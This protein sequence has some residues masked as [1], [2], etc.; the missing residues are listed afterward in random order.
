MSGAATGETGMPRG[1]VVFVGLMTLAAIAVAGIVAPLPAPIEPTWAALPVLALLLLAATW[2][3]V[4]FRYGGSVD[5]VNLIEA[6]LAPMLIAFPP[7]VVVAVAAASQIANGALRRLPLVKTVFNTAMWAVAAGLGSLVVAAAE[8]G[9]LWPH[10]I[11]QLLA[12]LAVVGIVNTMAFATVLSLVQGEPL[13]RLLTR[14]V[15]VVQLG[16]I[17]GWIV[18]AAMGVL[19]A[20]S[21]LASPVAVALFGVPL[22]VLHLAYRSYSTARADQIRLAS[23]HRAARSLAEPLQPLSAVPEF[24][25]E[26]AAAFDAGAAELV[27]RVDAGREIH[28]YQRP[29]GTYAV[30]AEDQDVASLEGVLAASPGVATVG[31]QDDGAVAAALRAAGAQDCLAAPLLD[32]E[33]LMGAV[34]VLDRGGF[35]GSRAG[36]LAIF[37]ALARETAGAL[38]KGRL[39]GDVLEERRKLAEIVD[40]ASDGICTFAEDGTVLTWNP[41]LEQITG[42]PAE[43]VVG[44]RDL[45][46]RLHVRTADGKPLDLRLRPLNRLP[47]DIRL[48]N[49]SGDRRHLTCSYSAGSKDLGGA[50]LIVMAR[51]VTPAEEHEA[52]RAQFSEL[53]E[54]DAARRVV[55][56]RLQETVVPPPIAVPGAEV[57][58]A[59]EASDPRAPTG[60]DLYDWQILPNGEL[61]VAVVDVLGHGVAATKDALAV[62]HTLRVLTASGTGLDDIIARADQ[63]LQAQHPD[64]VA[65][66]IVARYSPDTGR[67]R[68]AAGG[69]PPALVVTPRREVVQVPATGGVIGWPG[70]GSDNVSETVLEPG[71]ALVLYTDGLVEA[72]K[73]ILD[74]MEDLVRHAAEVAELPAAPF[75]R[76]LVVRALAGAER[77]DDTL[78]LVLRRDP[79]NALERHASWEMA[80]DA[81]EISQTRRALRDWLAQRGIDSMDACLA[82]G[83]LLANAMRSARTRVTLRASLADGCITLDIS[84]DGAGEPDLDGRGHVLPHPDTEQGRGLF[85]VR[86][87]SERVDVLST[88]E[89]STVRAV[90]RQRPAEALLRRSRRDVQDGA[91]LD[92][93]ALSS[94]EWTWA[95]RT[96]Y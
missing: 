87:L 26:L 7:I 32:G 39:L 43:Q 24:L 25:R 58:A 4:P 9:R 10:L 56:E 66:V 30:R 21:Y 89:G 72:R 62:V 79:V 69:H 11:L 71:D 59:Y 60:G 20:L 95:S 68:V 53:L 90:L 94:N 15:P 65:T 50:A 93:R 91:S 35:E 31:A 6:A 81:A 92:S 78:A 54:V 34:V 84:D 3:V 17:A 63:L 83:E 42:L 51:D 41:A 61:H 85:I 52:L 33:R 49:A 57:A 73:N 48:T 47:R 76:E 5:A 28:R 44:R 55:V 16:W 70:A 82:A 38:A 40:S 2:F 86:A 12:A 74:G 1:V 45:G 80:P 18:N 8:G 77:R 36:E 14:F 22:L 64:L 96:S 19:F 37:E 29:A 46:A 27:L 88:A 13:R 67:L 23:A 75:A